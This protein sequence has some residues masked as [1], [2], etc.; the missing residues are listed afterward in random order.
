[1]EDHTEA[2]RAAQRL[3]EQMDKKE[4]LISAL[5]EEGGF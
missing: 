1:M 5:K 4:H 2:I 3:S